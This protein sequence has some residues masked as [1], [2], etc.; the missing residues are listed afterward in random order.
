MKE[1]K[2][3]FKQDVFHDPDSN[4]FLLNM[5]L[6]SYREW[7]VGRFCSKW[8]ACYLNGNYQKA[9]KKFASYD[10]KSDYEL[11]LERFIKALGSGVK[12][13]AVSEACNTLTQMNS[14]RKT[15]LVPAYLVST[16]FLS[17]PIFAG[18]LV[19]YLVAHAFIYRRALFCSSL[20]STQMYFSLAVVSLATGAAAAYFIYQRFLTQ[21]R[22]RELRKHSLILHTE[23]DCRV[24]RILLHTVITASLIVLTLTAKTGVA[25]YPTGIVDN[26]RAL[27]QS[28]EMFS[29]IE[30]IYQTQDSGDCYLVFTSGSHYSCSEAAVRKFILPYTNVTITQTEASESI[31]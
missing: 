1:M 2:R 7:Y 24:R 11:R 6:R 30:A 10:N 13:S 18:Y 21:K 22:R 19:F 27:S 28:V 16:L 8:Y 15:A 29:A 23:S 26:T 4:A 31:G 12:Y 14:I 25:L 17:V 9:A 5:R 20:W 3:F